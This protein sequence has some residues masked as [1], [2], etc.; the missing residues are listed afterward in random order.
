LN[1]TSDFDA[2]HLNAEQPAG[3]AKPTDHDPSVAEIL[4]SANDIISSTSGNDVRRSG[5]GNDFFYLDEGGDDS[6]SGG[7][8]HDTFLFGATMTSADDVD[9]GAGT[10]QIALQGDYS[11]N[12]LTFGADVLA[13]EILAIL[14]GSDTRFGDPGTNFYDYIITTQNVN[15][16]PGTQMIVDANALRNDEDLTF[17]G[18]AET[19]GSFFIYAGGGADTLTGGALGDVFLFGENRWGGS[20]TVNGGGGLDQLVLRGDYTHTFGATQLAG[21]ENLA[22]LSAFDTRFGALGA[23]Y[24][25][26]LIMDDG[27][28]ADGAQM[29]VDAA[30]LR[31]SETLTFDGS[32]EADGSFRVFGGA[33]D[34]DIIGSQNADIIVGR[35]GADTLTGDGGNDVFRYNAADDS[36]SA[37][38]DEIQDFTLGDLL[39]LS[40]IDADT[41]QEG[42]QAFTFIEDEDFGLNPG[43]LRFEQVTDSSF[44]VQGDTDGDGDADFELLLI[45]ADLDPITSGDFIL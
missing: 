24:S 28:V 15:V 27:N 20:D 5:A 39:D 34:D 30:T 35:L 38:Q 29:T 26:D 11:V 37:G 41:T 13:V 6:A 32:D 9:G 36:T 22:L 16:A 43:E 10:D 19:D 42:N 2:V 25:Y 14:P 40:R 45:L 18:S 23:G 4:I 3:A 31:S 12:A 8:G 1:L 17:D 33:G 21:I 7:I 44:L